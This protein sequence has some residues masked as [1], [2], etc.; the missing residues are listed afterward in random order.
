MEAHGTTVA[1]K[2]KKKTKI[3]NQAACADLAPWSQLPITSQCFYNTWIITASFL[4]LGRGGHPHL[5]P[6]QNSVSTTGHKK[7][8]EG[9]GLC[10]LGE[11]TSPT[12]HQAW[13]K[14][15]QRFVVLR[16]SHQSSLLQ[17]GKGLAPEPLQCVLMPD[18]CGAC[19]NRLL[20]EAA[21]CLYP[22]KPKAH[23]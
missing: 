7:V 6:L 8:V 15:E 19:L 21:P 1:S 2:P 5:Q 3:Q 12:V 17:A 4:H 18:P 23:P 10:G 9:A 16:D 22:P 14:P 20:A 11:W 13:L